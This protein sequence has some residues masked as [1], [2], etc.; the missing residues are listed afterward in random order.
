[1]GFSPDGRDLLYTVSSNGG[2]NGEIYTVK[3]SGGS[4]VALMFGSNAVWGS[5]WIVFA[6]WRKPPRADDE[7]KVDL[8]LIK[9]SRAGLHRLTRTD[10][11]VLLSGLVPTA[12]SRN[13]KRLLAE[14][15]GEDV[16]YAEAVDPATGKVRLV[17]TFAQG[18]VGYG[19]SRDGTTVLATATPGGW[20]PGPNPHTDVVAVP[21]SGGKLRVLALHAH[22]PDWNANHG[23]R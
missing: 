10:A 12:W 16:S 1:M 23:T 18:L 15:T 22:D 8:Y 20:I 3:V 7:A 5:R 17:G 4:P 21:Y 2:L 14:F 9:P 13:G 6:R 19:L 11:P